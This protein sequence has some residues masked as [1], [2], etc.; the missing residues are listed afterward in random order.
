LDELLR[1]LL[2]LRQTTESRKPTTPKKLSAEEQLEAALKRNIE[3]ALSNAPTP[4]SKAPI[5]LIIKE[6]LIIQQ[7]VNLKVQA[8]V[9]DYINA[10]RLTNLE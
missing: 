3:E 2:E 8:W 5:L 9:D 7:R 10:A 1:M 6:Q 4:G